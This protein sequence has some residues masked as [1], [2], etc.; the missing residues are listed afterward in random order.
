MCNKWS[1]VLKENHVDAYDTAS[2]LH[3]RIEYIILG[4]EKDVYE[5]IFDTDSV[6]SMKTH[7]WGWNVVPLCY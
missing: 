4:T 7:D 5:K 6:L 2:S 1:E 3:H